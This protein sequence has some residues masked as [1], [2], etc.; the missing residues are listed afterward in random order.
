ME[1]VII[2]GT[3][4]AGY[5]AAIYTGRANLAPLM[6]TG[7]QPGG[8]LTT[9]TEVENF[10]GF[11]EGVMGPQLMMNMQAQAE[12]FGARIEFANVE[13]VEKRA[14]GSF[15]VK[16]S[17]GNHEAHT[18]IIA[19]GAAPKHLGL[20][21]EKE[22]DRPRPDVLRDLRRGFLPGRAGGGHRRRRQ[23]LRGGDFPDPLRQQ[24]LP[25]PP[26][27]RAAG[28]Q[29]HGRPGAWRIR[30]SSRCGIP[31]FPSISPTKPARC[32]P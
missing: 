25:D 27:R 11:P 3:G 22:L 10:P 12:K 24:G 20:P 19:T 26:P 23:R 5:T 29:N 31:P 21:N 13:G 28:L 2:I 17:S 14:D 7:T 16:T 32:G 1:N 15:L 9:T 8:Q 30:R 6:L 4:C 18:V